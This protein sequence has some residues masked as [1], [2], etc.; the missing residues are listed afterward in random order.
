[1]ALNCSNNHTYKHITNMYELFQTISYDTQHYISRK[2]Q[3]RVLFPLWSTLG[4][5]SNIVKHYLNNVKL[6]FLIQDFKEFRQARNKMLRARS[7]QILLSFGFWPELKAR[8]GPNI[9][10]MRSYTLK[11]G[12][13]IEWA[14]NWSVVF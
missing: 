6:F 13:M 4:T 12:T 11:P 9:Y 1:M 3:K 7:N 14:N 10:E 5:L 8:E 2:T